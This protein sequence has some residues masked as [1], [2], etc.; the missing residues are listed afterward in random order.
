VAEGAEGSWWLV[1]SM[2]IDQHL[3]NTRLPCSSSDLERRQSFIVGLVHGVLAV[4][5]ITA[6]VVLWS[7]RNECIQLT[8]LLLLLSSP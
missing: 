4:R 6:V 3:Y 8:V 2:S 1:K 5:W 7:S